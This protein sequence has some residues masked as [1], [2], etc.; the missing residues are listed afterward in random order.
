MGQDNARAP[1]ANGV[2]DN[3]A[4]GEGDRGR[5]AIMLADMDALR[6]GVEMCD[7]KPLAFLGLTFEAGG[8]EIA[9]SPMPVEERW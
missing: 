9:S 6:L 4:Y 7:E 1:E 3:R 5:V 8:E 2:G